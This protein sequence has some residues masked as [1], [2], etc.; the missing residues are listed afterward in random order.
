MEALRSGARVVPVT[1]VTGLYSKSLFLTAYSLNSKL[2]S[3]FAFLK[4]EK[5]FG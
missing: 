5:I 2:I 3:E 4:A 1:P